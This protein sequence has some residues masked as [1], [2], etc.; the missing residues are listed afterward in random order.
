MCYNKESLFS[1]TLLPIPPPSNRCYDHLTLA[2]S[3]FEGHYELWLG[4]ETMILWRHLKLI[5]RSYHENLK[6]LL[7]RAS[8]YVKDTYNKGIKWM[9]LE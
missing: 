3:T 6:F 9:L 8:E 4:P 7:T 1:L 5:W 2:E